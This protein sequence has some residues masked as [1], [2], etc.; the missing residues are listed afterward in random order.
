MSNIFH[1]SIFD[2]QVAI[3]NALWHKTINS[4]KV[5]TYLHQST[6]LKYTLR[7]KM[8]SCVVHIKENYISSQANLD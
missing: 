8:R 5:V 3:L 1:C 6:S 7:N 4:A 2:I